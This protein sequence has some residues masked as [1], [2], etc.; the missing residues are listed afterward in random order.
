MD[1][2]QQDLRYALR[3]LRSNPAFV[4]ITVLTPTL[5]RI[6]TQAEWVPG[7]LDTVVISNGLCKRQFGSGPHVIGRS[8]LVDALMA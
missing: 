4:T 5:G 3:T 2:P 8:V 1:G 7:F 6:C